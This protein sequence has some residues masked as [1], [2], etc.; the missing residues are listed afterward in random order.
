ANIPIIAALFT[1]SL[2]LGYVYERQRALI[3][4]MGLHA[5]FNGISVLN[6][7]FFGGYTYFPL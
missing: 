5:M 4:P 1:F 6:L 7:Y 3:A 2:F